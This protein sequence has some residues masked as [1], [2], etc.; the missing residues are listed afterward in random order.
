MKK[1]IK[2]TLSL[3]FA[4]TMSTS[5]LAACTG[6]NSPSTPDKGES[7]PTNAVQNN[8][9]EPPAVKTPLEPVK[10]EVMLWGDKPKQFDEIV[11]EFE[12]QTKDTLNIDLNVTW[13][14]LADYGNKIKL[15]LSAGQKIDLA[16][17]APWLNMP[18][19]IANGSY[20][21]LDKYFNNDQY[22]GLQKAFG[23]SLLNNNK[24]VGPDKQQHVYGV[25]LGQGYAP[26]YAL[27]YRKD[28]AK[29][30]GISE[31]K[32]YDDMIA[33]FDAVKNNEPGITPYI[34]NKDQY[35]PAWIIDGNRA[36]KIDQ[37]KNNIW[38]VSTGSAGVAKLH[39]VDNKIKAAYLPGES[40][41]VLKDFPEPFHALD[42]TTNEEILN[43]NEK[44]Y[45]ESNAINRKDAQD[46][47][48]AG[49]AGSYMQTLDSYVA[50]ENAL[51][52]AVPGSELGVYVYENNVRNMEP[53][54]L[55][56]EF[57]FWN[58]LSIPAS[59]KNADRSMMFLDWIFASQQNHDLFEY[60]IEGKNW[61]AVG[62]DKYKLP[63]G[64]DPGQNYAFPGYQLTWNPNYMRLAEAYPQDVV[65]YYSYVAQ[66]TTFLKQVSA[67]FTFNGEPVKT[68]MTN[69]SFAKMAAENAGFELGLIK[70]IADNKAKQ[71]QNLL[72]DK[73]LQADIQKIKAELVQQL[74]AFLDEQ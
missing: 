7:S 68:E 42:F 70:N 65:E 15:M 23:E 24:F 16:F 40:T 29:K 62:D 30:H 12:R 51:K 59:S 39:I 8:S 45:I 66:D 58:F 71:E 53:A 72:K 11:D 9:S 61:V 56:T 73:Q 4:V 57:K 49:T 31:L 48:T 36:I 6:K 74:Q 25:P 50:L 67:G 26:V 3:I 60:G 33:Y 52:A 55:L 22:P 1:G 28:L 5:L 14:P 13:T 32:S 19:L 34:F 44:G 47:F 17:D 38:E 20:I 41:D 46:Q 21:E 18:G 54:S 35:P 69:P 2:K 10:L 63:D 64:V 43:W 37:A 27:Y